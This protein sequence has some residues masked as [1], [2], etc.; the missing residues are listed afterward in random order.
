MVLGLRISYILELRQSLFRTQ[1]FTEDL[2]EREI[3]LCMKKK[4]KKNP[5]S[6]ILRIYMVCK[7]SIKDCLRFVGVECYLQYM[8]VWFV[9]LFVYYKNTKYAIPD[10][11]Q[12]KILMTEWQTQ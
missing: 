6:V 3:L 7:N 10:F 8:G 2:A 11:H 4:K 9:L 12:G 1:C 5:D